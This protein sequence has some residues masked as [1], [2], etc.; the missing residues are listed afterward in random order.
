MHN[1]PTVYQIDQIRELETLA[2]ERFG[3]TGIVMME[4]AGKSAFAYLMK[5]WPKAKRIAV[6]CGTGNNGGDGYVLAKIAHQSKLQVNVWQVGNAQKLKAEALQAFENCKNA[7]VAIKPFL[8][9]QHFHDVDVIVDALLGIGLQGEIN[10]DAKLAIDAM[11]F[12][13]APIL[14]LDIPSGLDADAGSVL[15]AAVKATATITFL[16]MKVGLLTGEGAAYAGEL[17]CDDLALPADMY[18]L[19]A[20][21][22]EK[23]RLSQFAKFLKPRARDAHKGDMGHVLIVGGAEGFI[24]AARMAAEAA[25]RVGAG[26]VSVATSPSHSEYFNLTRP[27]IMCHGV[28][29]AEQLAPL[30]EKASVVVIGPGLGQSAWSKMLLKA[31]LQ[32]RLPLVVDADALNLIS[33]DPC[34]RNNW[35]LTPHPGEAA[36]LLKQTVSVVQQNRLAALE[37]LQQIY[38]GVC[39]LK[40]AG[41]LILAPSQLPALCDAGNPGMA[42]GG[43]GDVLSGVIGG[44]A[45]QG[46]SLADA[47][48]LGVCLHAIAGD[49]AAKDGGERGLLAMDL[50]PYL[51]KLA[52]LDI[53]QT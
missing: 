29:T 35:V 15:S 39:V 20:P 24:G 33:A 28:S 1:A 18:P 44:L 7:G 4:R 16:G 49:A 32:T 17:Y 42:T 43:M 3:I 34:S 36:R 41:T 37:K 47:A 11:N 53:K 12:S 46:V 25:L 38:E 21:K 30:L 27:E 51:R 5:R 8:H 31:V 52:N 45:A 23:L 6:I 19:I 22:I 40:G 2:R 50:M 26:L 13:E 14:A 9:A 48:K 10:H